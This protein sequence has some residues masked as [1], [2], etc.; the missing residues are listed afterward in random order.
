M[1]IFGDDLYAGQVKSQAFTAK[2]ADDYDDWKSNMWHSG[3]DS[4]NSN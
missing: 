2:A 3:D 4:S 1:I